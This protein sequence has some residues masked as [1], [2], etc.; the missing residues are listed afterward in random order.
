MGGES[1]VA[2]RA[3]I[4]HAATAGPEMTWLSFLHRTVTVGLVGLGACAA[5]KDDS[6]ACVTDLPK[7]CSPLYDPPTFDTI[8]EKILH[9]TCAEGIATCHTTDGAKAGLV[10]ENVDDA[11]ALLLGKRDGRARVIPNNPGCSLIVIRTQSSDPNFRMPPGDVPLP[12]AEFCDIRLW[13]EQGAP[14]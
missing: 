8:Y 14:R 13:I 6:P 7:T 9:P 2:T 11:Y 12:D 5:K 10:F 1:I 4:D 3:G